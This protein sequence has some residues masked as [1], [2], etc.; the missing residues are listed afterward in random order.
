MK[1]EHA[2]LE[3]HPGKIWVVV[4]HALERADR[5]LVVA[6]FGLELGVAESGVEIVGLEQQALEQEVGRDALVR[7]SSWHGGR[8]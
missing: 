8:R 5:R 4:E 1:I 7:I 2:E 3:L 6:E